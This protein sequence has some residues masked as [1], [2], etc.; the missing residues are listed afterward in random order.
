MAKTVSTGWRTITPGA[1]RE[2]GF[3]AGWDCNERGN[4]LCDCQVC[5]D[6]DVLDAYGFH[7]PGCPVLAAT[8]EVSSEVF[9]RLPLFRREGMT[10]D[11]ARFHAAKQIRACRAAGW[12]VR[13][14][15]CALGDRR[16]YDLL[17]DGER[18]GEIV[19]IWR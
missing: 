15:D 1:C 19:L 3:D 7:N 12:Y 17:L 5:P 4:V 10:E 8:W 14:S 9:G 2:C 16:L 13:R 6:C 11:L 18:K